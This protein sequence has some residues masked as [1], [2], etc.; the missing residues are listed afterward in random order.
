MKTRYYD[1][2]T[3]Q[4][5]ALTSEELTK[6]IKLEAAERGVAVPLNLSEVI[7]QQGYVGH[8]VPADAVGFYQIM[9]PSRYGGAGNPSGV[10]FKTEAEALKAIEGAIC[11]VEEG[12]APNKK[13]TISQGEFAV[14]K[15]F[16]TAGKSQQFFTAVKEYEESREEYDTLCEEIRSDLQD[17]RQRKYDTEV[18][19]AKKA[20]YLELA[21]G[22]ETTAKR[23]WTNIEKTDWPQ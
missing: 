15:V 17:L 18:T 21:D 16:L 20:K 22:D 13:M 1:L 3:E 19:A 7:Q 14:Q 9:A 23:F 4:K 8:H 11:L 2:S 12:Y 10:C 5:L 6:A